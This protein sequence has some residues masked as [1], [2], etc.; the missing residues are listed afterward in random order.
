LV[1]HAATVPINLHFSRRR[2]LA[3]SL[4]NIG[5]GLGTTLMP[6]LLTSL[7]DFYGWRGTFL[8]LSGMYL[9][10]LICGMLIR[11]VKRTRKRMLFVLLQ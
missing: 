7:L 4:A 3:N 8:I 10:S 5:S 6:L 1:F 2:A 9:Q 11:P